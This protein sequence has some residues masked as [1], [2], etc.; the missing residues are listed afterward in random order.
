MKPRFGILPRTS[1]A[2]QQMVTL[3]IHC[4]EKATFSYITIYF[5]TYYFLEREYKTGY[6]TLLRLN[7]HMNQY[8]N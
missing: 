4:C 2:C 5:L 3:K 1:L 8:L 7:A 6:R